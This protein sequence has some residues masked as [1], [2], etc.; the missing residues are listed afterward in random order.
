M[1]IHIAYE[2]DLPELSELY[3]QTV[4]VHSPTYYT[5]AQTAAWVSTAA[6]VD[7]FRQ[8]ILGVTTFVAVN[9]TDILGFAGIGKNGYVGFAEKIKGCHYP[10]KFT[11]SKLLAPSNPV[12]GERPVVICVL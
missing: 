12:S 9:G 10:P 6:D 4:L 7:R 11:R 5:P 3:R 8:F 1:N 2:T